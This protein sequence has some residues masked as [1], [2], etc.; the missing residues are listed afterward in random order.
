[1]YVHILMLYVCLYV[2]EHLVQASPFV[3]PLHF[4]IKLM[5]IIIIIIE[6]SLDVQLQLLSHELM[7]QCDY[8]SVITILLHRLLQPCERRL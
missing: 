2:G 3:L 8:V 6:S 1:M 5:M 7:L 4:V